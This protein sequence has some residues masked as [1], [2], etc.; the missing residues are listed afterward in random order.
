MKQYKINM[1]SAA[2]KVQGHGVLSAYQEQVALVRDGLP[3]NF[4]VTENA[5]AG[6][7]ITHYH[8]VNLGYFLTLPLAKLHGKTVGYVHFLPETI[9]DSLRL[10]A[11]AK[12]VFY[13][14]LIHFYKSMDRL[15]TVN[16]CF[17]DKLE[18]YGIPREKVS[19]IPNY[20]SEKEF[21]PVSVGEKR[22]LRLRYGLDPDRFTVVCA[23]QLQT[24][25][26]VMDFVELARRLPE[27]QFLWAGGFSFGA[28]TDGY[29][30]IS[31][32]LKNPPENAKFPGIIPREEMNGIYNL[33]DVMFL[34]SYGELFP[35]TILEAMCCNTPLLLRDIDIYPKI[36]FDFYLKG[37]TQEEFEAQLLRLQN[38]PAYYTLAQKSAARGHGFYNAD[39]VLSMW[40]SFYEDLVTQPKGSEKPVLSKTAVG[41]YL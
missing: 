16:P 9:E 22:A 25:K 17:I 38:E 32:M 35:M 20:V 30:E 13:W 10:I 8:T 1:K 2:D 11:P 26:G 33:G 19:Y 18:A 7:D 24:R 39:H 31:R 34:P 41:K 4:S 14:Y 29:E 5:M 12:K 27:M 40:E 37:N 28:M 23:G 36:L 21:Y 6:A 15:V 3:E